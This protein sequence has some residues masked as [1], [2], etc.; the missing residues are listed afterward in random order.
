MTQ[1][2]LVQTGRTIWDEQGRLESL[3][4]VPLCREGME[5][6]RRVAKELVPHKPTIIY[7]AAGEAEQQTAKLLTDELAMKIKTDRRLAE[8]DFGLWQGLTH[9]EIKRRQPRLHKQWLETPANVRPPGGETLDEASTRIAE[10]LDD[11]TKKEKKQSPIL[12]LRPIA[13]GLLRCRLENA[14]LDEFWSRVS[15]DFTWICYKQDNKTSAWST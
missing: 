14:S 2:L 7:A 8:V 3:A 11:I 4:G 10:A 12:V 6:I 1:L 5:T 9:E 13:L 15:P